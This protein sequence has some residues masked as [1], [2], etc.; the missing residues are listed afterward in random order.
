MNKQ[1]HISPSYD[2]NI[3]RKSLIKSGMD[4]T[5]IEL[6]VKRFEEGE[7]KDY[8]REFQGALSYWAEILQDTKQRVI[9]TLDG[10]DTAGKGSNIKKVNEQLNNRKFG[11]TAFEGIPT[12]EERKGENWFKKFS[13]SFPKKG[14]IQFYDRSW[15][16]RAGVEAA[17]GFCTQEEYDWFMQYVNNF[18]AGIV[19]EGFD[20]LKIYLSIGKKVQKE[21]LKAREGVRKRWK[22]SPVDAE[23]QE[24]WGQYT[25]AKHQILEHTDSAHAPWII[26]DS[27]ERFL[28]AGEIIKAIIGTRDDVRKTI[29]KELSLDLSPDNNIV[30]TG[31]QELDRMKELGQI[32]TGK[33]FKFKEVLV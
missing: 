8:L 25:L 30:R 9:V 17:M 19:D 28:S 26:I 10:R 18:E 33:T 11:V 31:K 29:S 32:P 15:Y 23:A 16:N 24:K 20:F 13:S 14:S 4:V 21:R 12:P 5:M 7:E 2:Q 6:I 27:T 3:L 22:S 1:N